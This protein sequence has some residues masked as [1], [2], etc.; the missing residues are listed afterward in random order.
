M[1]NFF[2]YFFFYISIFS[3]NNSMGQATRMLKKNITLVMPGEEGSNGCSVAWHPL[4]KKY[5]TAIAGK[6]NHPLAVFDIGG[7]RISPDNLSSLIDFRGLWFNPETKTICGNGFRN[8]GWFSYKLNS[9]GMP[10]ETSMLLEGSYQPNEQSVGAYNPKNELVYFLNSL[11]IVAYNKEGKQLEDSSI[12]LLLKPD[13]K[14]ENDILGYLK[15]NFNTTSII[16]TGILNSEFG[17]LN[18][19][20]PQIE[21]YNKKSGEI[22]Q[23]LKLPIDAYAYDWLNFSFAN[24]IYW[25]FDKDN[26]K[27][28]GYK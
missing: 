12:L 11:K 28:V 21:L 4:Q 14:F 23:I 2:L 15:E 10:Q 24:G 26:R 19:T 7:K 18:Y 22:S 9:L 20:K 1:N 25:L 5:Y 16:Y 27:W 8:L 17:L 6:P 3:S 13:E